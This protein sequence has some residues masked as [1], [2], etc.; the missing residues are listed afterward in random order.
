MSLELCILASGSSGNA[1][2]LRGPSGTLLIDLGLGPRTLAKRLGGTGVRVADVSAVCLTHLDSD[3]FNAN[4]ASTLLRRGIALHCHADRAGHLL[5]L[6]SDD[7]SEQDDVGRVL[8][9]FDAAAFSP[10]PGITIE[11]IALAHDVEGSHGFLIEGFG[12]RIGYATDLGHVPRHLLERLGE[13]RLD[14]LAIESNYDPAMQEASARPR[15]LKR[16]IM[17]GRG[18]LSNEQ[19]L[20]AVRAVLDRA[21]ATGQRLPDHIVLLHRSRQCNCPR[22]LRRLF[23]SDRRIAPRLVLAEQYERTEWL[24]ARGTAPAPGEQLLLAWG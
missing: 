6:V 17:G 23:E 5:R 7:P 15:F 10:L 22:L 2:V 9:P 18:H 14:L 16:R 1:A 20:G 3:H 21:A 4:W 13:R 24:R 12:C 11:P 19:A 8:R